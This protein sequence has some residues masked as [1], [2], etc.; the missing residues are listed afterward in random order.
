MATGTG[1]S[2]L[3]VLGQQLEQRPESG[4]VVADTQL[5]HLIAVGVDQCHVVVVFRPVDTAE[6]LVLTCVLRESG[7]LRST[8]RSNRS[9]PGTPSHEPFVSPATGRDLGLL[10]S[11]KRLANC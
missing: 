4:A 6:D 8:R 3:A 10:E 2:V 1:S 11:S 5:G 7:S 9:A